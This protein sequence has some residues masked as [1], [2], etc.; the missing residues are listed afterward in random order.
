ME[1]EGSL[2]TN[3]VQEEA[4][5][6]LTLSCHSSVYLV[7][8][9]SR[10]LNF[11][12]FQ[13][14]SVSLS[15]M[16]CEIV[17]RQPVLRA[18]V[19][20]FILLPPRPA[21]VACLKMQVQLLMPTPL[22]PSPPWL[23]LSLLDTLPPSREKWWP[24]VISDS[25]RRLNLQTP[26]FHQPQREK[27]KGEQYGGRCSLK[28]LQLLMALIVRSCCF[29]VYACHGLRPPFPVFFFLFCFVFLWGT[30]YDN[31]WFLRW[32][33]SL[34]SLPFSFSRHVRTSGYE[35]QMRAGVRESAAG[36]SLFLK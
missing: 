2:N 32:F 7:C 14:S 36:S 12:S 20:Q 5:V 17:Y 4:W 30:T 11:W 25:L 15:L 19:G 13:M 31:C 23:P 21:N 9:F 29:P 8:P 3:K 6:T 33:F 27:G 10:R 26:F 35:L 16:N 24:S 22:R 28:D 34:L 1:Q 18:S